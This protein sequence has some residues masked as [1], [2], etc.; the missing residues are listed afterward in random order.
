MGPWLFYLLAV[1]FRL[2]GSSPVGLLVGAGI[3][4]VTC[5]V[6]IVRCVR[7]FAGDLVAASV[8]VAMVVFLITASGDRLIDPWN[9][10]VVQLPFLLTVI[11]AWAVLNARPQWMT[12]VVAAGS[13]CVQSHIAFLVPVVVLM[14]ASVIGTIRGPSGAGRHLLRAGVVLVI[15]WLP[16]A[17]DLVLPGRHNMYKVARW[18]LRS[19]TAPT[20]GLRAGLDVVLHET[21][22]GASWI[23][24][25]VRTRPLIASYD[26]SLGHLPG[27]GLLIVA[28]AGVLAWRWRHR[29]IGTLVALLAA[30]LA[31]AALEM[32]QARGPLYPYLFG[33]V[34]VT[35]LLC[36]IAG[37]VAVT[38]AWPSIDE[39]LGTI[40][41]LGA[42]ACA[43][44]LV[45]TGLHAGLPLSPLER[46]GD[47]AIVRRLVSQA[48][49]RLSRNTT[50]ALVHGGDAYNSIYELGVAAAIRADGFHLVAPPNAVVLFGQHMIDPA[51]GSDEQLTVDSPYETN[52]PTGDAVAVDDPLR[53]AERAWETW[54]VQH[55]TAAYQAAGS[56]DAVKIVAAGEGNDVLLAG[57]FVHDPSLDPFLHELAALRSRGRS[58]AIV[59]WPAR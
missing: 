51:A 36:W 12:C 55:L 18:F 39:R 1:P 53:P 49:T 59:T 41:R 37:V 21:G 20:N 8:A 24:G 15:V 4:N 16:T 47:S 32:S 30:L 38:V 50:Y 25:H 23:G 3:I 44:T 35:G 10:W 45:W 56:E 27:A 34:T 17:I 6:L 40:I 57:Y 13:L 2:L 22:L 48:E 14:V 7:S 43:L 29:V 5:V 58:V 19:S 28:A 9:P 46:T 26:G 52:H 54:L 42:T 33:W 31:A 11:S